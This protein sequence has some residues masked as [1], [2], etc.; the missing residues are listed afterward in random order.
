MK[1]QWLHPDD[2][3]EVEGQTGG[4]PVT[5]QAQATEIVEPIVPDL[6]DEV[7]VEAPDEVDT[8]PFEGRLSGLESSLAEIKGLLSKREQPKDDAGYADDEDETVLSKQLRSE[9]SGMSKSMEE[10]KTVQ[11]NQQRAS[12]QYSDR[13]QVATVNYEATQ[14]LDRFNAG[15]KLTTSQH[16]ACQKAAEQVKAAVLRQVNQLVMSNPTGH[17]LTANHIQHMWS[18]QLSERRELLQAALVGENIG[19]QVETN[20]ESGVEAGSGAPPTDKTKPIASPNSD[21]FWA[22][23]KQQIRD[24]V[25]NR[26]VTRQASQ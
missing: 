11:Q 4:E 8:N 1:N 3:G 14:L 5:D 22:D 20:S 19:R 12:K 21:D 7:V 23:K 24:R 9:I 2:P 10:I 13:S 6:G 25:L 26:V 18:E 17:G 15:H 16:P